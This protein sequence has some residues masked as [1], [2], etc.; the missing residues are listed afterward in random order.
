MTTHEVTPIAGCRYDLVPEDR[1]VVLVEKADPGIGWTDRRTGRPKKILYLRCRILAGS[2]KGTVLFM[3]LNLTFRGKSPRPSSAFYEA[4]TVAMDRKPVRGERMSPRVFEGKV[5]EAE[6]V[7]V[8]RD[9]K[10]RVRPRV[11]QYSKIARLL[12]LLG[13][14]DAYFLPQ[15]EDRRPETEYPIP[16]SPGNLAG[17]AGSSEQDYEMPAVGERRRAV[18]C[19][20][21]ENTPGGGLPFV[22]GRP[23]PSTPQNS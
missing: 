10:G 23:A 6:V 15:T 2:F 4:W 18:G 12:T 20:K 22:I 21:Q 14:E 8:A 5:F 19:Q 16:P 17:K 13:T 11:A 9:S 7:T 1:Y 3:P